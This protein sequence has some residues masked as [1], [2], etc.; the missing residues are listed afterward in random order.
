ML[1]AGHINVRVVTPAE[2]A[3][4]LGEPALIATGRTPITPLAD[5]ALAQELAR[6]AESYFEPVR[7]TPG[8]ADA[9]HRL[10]GSFGPPA[11]ARSSSP[12]RPPTP[13]STSSRTS[14]AA[15]SIHQNSAIFHAAVSADRLNWGV[16]GAL[17]SR[18]PAKAAD[19]GRSSSRLSTRAEDG[20]I[21]CG[22][23]YCAFYHIMKL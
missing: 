7:E 10:S 13:S 23:I 15:I 21:T 22:S 12:R 18:G 19:T 9:L 20:V 8:F 16:R 2:L 4:R 5:R 11:S 1:L 3:L 14:T 17:T 6:H